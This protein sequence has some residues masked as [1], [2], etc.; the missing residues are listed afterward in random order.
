MIDSMSH[1][2]YHPHKKSK[3]DKSKQNHLLDTF[4]YPLAF[5][6]PVMTIPQLLDVWNPTHKASVSLLTWTAYTL[7]AFFWMV[8]GIQHKEKPII[9]ANLLGFIFN[10]LIVVGILFV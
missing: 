10:G 7:A 1:V 2:Y 8:Y 9:V 6:S 4:M 3:Q 5:A